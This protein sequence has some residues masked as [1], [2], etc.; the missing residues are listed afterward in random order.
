M[1]LSDQIVASLID[2]QIALEGRFLVEGGHAGFE[3]AAG[4]FDVA[5]AV[6]NADDDRRIVIQ[7]VHKIPFCC[8]TAKGGPQTAQ[9]KIFLLVTISVTDM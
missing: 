6:V 2:Q 3:T 8:I 9:P 1:F 7:N 5:I 4:S